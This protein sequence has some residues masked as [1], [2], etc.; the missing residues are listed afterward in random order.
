[1]R[2]GFVKPVEVVMSLHSCIKA[3]KFALHGCLA[4]AAKVQCIVSIA[5]PLLAPGA[6]CAVCKNMPSSGARWEATLGVKPVCCC[7][8]TMQVPQAQQP[9]TARCLRPMLLPC[10]GQQQSCQVICWRLTRR[11]QVHLGCG[12]SLKRQPC[13]DWHGISVRP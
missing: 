9:R 13:K 11:C 3:L 1:M 6:V 7:D 10:A 12:F 8:A 2:V 4:S 5:E